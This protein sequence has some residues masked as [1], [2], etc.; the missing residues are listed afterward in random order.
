MPTATAAAAAATTTI[1]AIKITT[2]S[3]HR[4]WYIARW[5]SL[6][7]VRLENH[8]WPIP[9]S[10]A[11]FRKRMTRPLKACI[12]RPFVF[13]KFIV[14]PIL[15][16]QPG[17]CVLSCWSSDDGLSGR[18]VVVVA[19]C[20]EEEKRRKK[21]PNHGRFVLSCFLL[22]CPLARLSGFVLP[23]S[24]FYNMC[25]SKWVTRTTFRCTFRL[26]LCSLNCWFARRPTLPGRIF[27]PVPQCLARCP[28]LYF[29]LLPDESTIVW[30]DRS[31]QWCPVEHA[32]RCSGC[33][34][35]L[36][37]QHERFGRQQ[38]TSQS[39]RCRGIGGKLRRYT[40]H[41]MLEQDGGKCRR[42]IPHVAQRNWKRWR[43]IDRKWQRRMLHSVK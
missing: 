43:T 13:R 31:G 32:G 39:C 8:P 14:P 5:L 24:R 18:V 1:P 26:F 6:D 41:R 37:G 11:T 38:A 15:S 27:S 22:S 7:F 2:T 30:S 42:G 20:F 33:S 34:T 25:V 3:R 21:I 29:G 4:P 23:L 17:W 10:P 9:L 36:G 28:W 40:L 19:C 12:T 35:C 16:I